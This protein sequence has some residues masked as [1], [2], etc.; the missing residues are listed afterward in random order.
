MERAGTGK[1]AVARNYPAHGA[2]DE[3]RWLRSSGVL[4]TTLLRQMVVLADVGRLAI[5]VTLQMGCACLPASVCSLLLSLDSAASFL[6]C[7]PCSR[8]PALATP[9]CGLLGLRHPAAGAAFAA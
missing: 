6:E 1:Y 9:A 5:A 3:S 8:R 7:G 4:P 2:S